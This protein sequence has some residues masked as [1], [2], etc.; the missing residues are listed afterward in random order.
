M[1]KTDILSRTGFTCVFCDEVF[2]ELHEHGMQIQLH[3]TWNTEGLSGYI[4]ASCTGK[5]HFQK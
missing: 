5:N 1:T 3:S 4:C 2:N